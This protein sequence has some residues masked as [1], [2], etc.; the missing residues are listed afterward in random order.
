M[1]NI[2]IFFLITCFSTSVFAKVYKCIDDNGKVFYHD[3]PIKL[4]KMCAKKIQIIKTTEKSIRSKDGCVGESLALLKNS[5]N[6]K[7][8][9]E[10]SNNNAIVKLLQNRQGSYIA[11]GQINDQ[12]V[13]FVVDTGAFSIA[14]P[15]RVAKC[16]KLKK[17]KSLKASTANGI[18]SVYATEMD[19]I[20]LGAIKM[21]NIQAVITPNQKG[22]I[23][24]LGMNF[25][26]KLEMSQK[27]N[28]LRLQYKM[29]VKD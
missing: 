15:S 25:L 2:L 11:A 26:K 10:S 1:K 9:I 6:E 28:Q 20:S 21:T 7:V 3:N 27:N 18:T 24:L 8:A 22:D 19:S 16:L 14:I 4:E 13:T 12:K 29:L 5:P 17:G 23:I